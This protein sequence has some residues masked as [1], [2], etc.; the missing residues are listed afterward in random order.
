MARVTQLAVKA[1]TENTKMGNAAGVVSLDTELLAQLEEEV[2]ARLN[3]AGYN[4]S[5]WLDS[6]TTPTI[7]R[8]AIAKLYVSWLIDRQYSEDEDL[9]AYAG[10]LAAN[11]EQVIEG[12]V[13]GT[14]TIP[15]SPDGEV[16]QPSFYPNDDSSAATPTWEDT[17]LGPAKF[18]MGQVF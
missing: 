4:T 1:W 13:A 18:S 5:T 9:N 15:G 12:L 16:G 11:A 6:N 2:I 3:G 10:R 17:S 8:T 14:L 7:V